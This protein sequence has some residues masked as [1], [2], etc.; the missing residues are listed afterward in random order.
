MGRF[1]ARLF[2]RR[3]HR[4]RVIPKSVELRAVLEPAGDH[5]VLDLVVHPV[6][7]KRKKPVENHR[8]LVVRVPGLAV[9]KVPHHYED[10]ISIS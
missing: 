3:A 2:V 7:A 9:L 6:V 5:H 1:I 10:E 4:A 8:R